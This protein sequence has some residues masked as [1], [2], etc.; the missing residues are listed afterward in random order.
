MQDERVY[1]LR[2]QAGATPGATLPLR[3]AHS[4]R[5]L[6]SR[7]KEVSGSLL[8]FPTNCGGSGNLIL[9]PPSFHRLRRPN[10]PRSTSS[11]PL[12]P[13][14]DEVGMDTDPVPGVSGIPMLTA[15][16]SRSTTLVFILLDELCELWPEPDM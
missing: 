14:S 3:C 1:S 12:R 6:I 7:G 16:P 2:G 13:V 5:P 4:K 8:R 9:S 11:R 10:S 15:A